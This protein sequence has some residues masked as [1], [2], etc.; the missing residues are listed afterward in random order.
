VAWKKNEPFKE[1]GSGYAG[2]RLFLTKISEEKE[3]ERLYELRRRS[4]PV[5]KERREATYLVIFNMLAY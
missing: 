3:T 5:D 4:Y 1:E 2:K